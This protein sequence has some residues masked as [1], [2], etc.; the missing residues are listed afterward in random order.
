LAG[1]APNSFPSV[2]APALASLRLSSRGL[3]T[4]IRQ[5]LFAVAN[6]EERYL[7]NA[8]LLLLREDRMGMVATDGRRLSLVEVQEDS[9]AIDGYRK[10]LLPRDAMGDLL[11]L[12]GATKEESIGFSEDDTTRRKTNQVH[13]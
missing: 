3:K 4:L 9:L 10:V 11:S 2:S 13:S 6:S 1:V 12:F 5:S 7:F 8:A